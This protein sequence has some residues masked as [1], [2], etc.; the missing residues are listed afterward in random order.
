MHSNNQPMDRKNAHV[1][2]PADAQL[3]P[4][5]S[6][7]YPN[8][9]PP[10]SDYPEGGKQ[11]W[12]TVAGAWACMFVSF[13]WVNCVGIF[14]DY[15]QANQLRQYTPSEIA[16]I[17]SLQIFFMIFGGLFV[18]KITDDC[19]P[20]IPLAFGAFLHVLGLM[21]VSTAN[22]YFQI[23]LSQAVCSAIGSSM[24]FYPAVTCVSTWFL[25]KR[26]AAL[27]IV[28]MG[29]SIGGVV[30][31][32]MLINLIPKVGFGWSMRI[33][34]FIILA[35]LVVAN[36]T[37][38]C[39]IP[40]VKRP[41]SIVA[42][43][44]PLTELDFIL[45]TLAIFFFYWG[46]FIPLTFIVV[47]ARANGFPVH[48]LEYLVP[49]LN[50]ASIIGRTVPNALADKLG[51]FNV[52][53]AMSAFTTIL[54]LAVWLPTS[55]TGATIAFAAL[56]GIASG[57]GIGLTPVLV[58]AMSPIQDIGVRTGSAFSVSAFAGLTG[59]PIA[60]QL[61]VKSGGSFDNAKIFSGVSCAI[62]TVLYVAS[63]Q[64]VNVQ[65]ARKA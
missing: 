38:R 26:G 53:I 5:G 12:L 15:Y 44:R 42:L 29:S 50:A 51:H 37:I 31:P 57:A 40:P 43:F 22:T 10:L 41:F 3:S 7:D 30:F 1:S 16:W 2:D 36:L 55:G 27:G 34:A 60:G 45:L 62:A 56:F 52:M 33:C 20:G 46:M 65:R 59:S 13:G 49:I 63:R 28:V 18:G 9:P 11:A 17:P 54:I 19:G 4:R 8:A 39:R 64:A 25:K 6:D 58:A 23:I 47:E 61:V 14:Q 32:V 35:L 24:V 21:I 48:L